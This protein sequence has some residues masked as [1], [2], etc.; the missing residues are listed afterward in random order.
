MFFVLACGFVEMRGVVGI[1][2]VTKRKNH[3]EIHQEAWMEWLLAQTAVTVFV[4]CLVFG[5]A[6]GDM[7]IYQSLFLV[8]V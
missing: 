6:G 1:D 2:R 5:V 4:V 3:H 8:I 7:S